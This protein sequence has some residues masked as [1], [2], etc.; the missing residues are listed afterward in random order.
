MPNVTQ[1]T[2]NTALHMPARRVFFHLLRH[3]L[4]RACTARSVALAFVASIGCLFAPLAMAAEASVAVA[5]NFL[6]PMKAIAAIL[7]KTTGHRLTLSVGSSGKLYAQITN[8]APYDIF[9][10]ADTER[11]ALLEQAGVASEGM[12]WTY[13]KGK[14]VLWSADPQKIDPNGQVLK[15]LEAY[16]KIAYANPKTAPYGL[17]ATQVLDNL[18][19]T[20]STS[21][22]LVQGESIGQTYSFIQTGNADIGFVAMSQVVR[23]GK[24][25]QGSM[26]EIPP[27][28]YAPIHQDAIVLK[29]GTHNDAALA[30][31]KLMQTPA[32]RDLIRS[33]GYGI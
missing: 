32:I 15:N 29:R 16:R 19:L 28:L 18:G 9:F 22:R 33:Y 6:E 5:A 30:L 17:A 25:S 7:E 31:M 13:A 26:W 12:R 4:S 10:S 14:L 2:P 11:P 20:A 8:G 21:S 24:L 23:N 27:S 3:G 1:A